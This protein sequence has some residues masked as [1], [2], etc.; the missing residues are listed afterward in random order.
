MISKMRNRLHESRHDRND[1]QVRLDDI[2]N[3]IRG[4][5]GDDIRRGGIRRYGVSDK[6]V[7]EIG[8]KG[9]EMED[10]VIVTVIYRY[11]ECEPATTIYLASALVS[12][13]FYW[14]SHDISEFER[15]LIDLKGSLHKKSAEEG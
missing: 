9:S 14:E 12:D 3:A 1:T 6:Y 7:Y 5:L 11:I 15:D 10:D 13:D 2:L 8:L 4:L